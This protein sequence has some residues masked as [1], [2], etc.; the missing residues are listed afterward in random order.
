MDPSSPPLLI[1][2]AGES[3]SYGKGDLA[4]SPRVEYPTST[5]E[6][7]P[8][9]A[10]ANR[11][12]RLL[13]LALNAWI[14]FH[15]AAIVIAP[16]AVRPASD[17]VEAG[18]GLFQPY[19]QI[20]DLNH[21]YHFFAPEPEAST[22]LAFEAQR[23]DGT[24][25]KGRIPNREIVP[26]LLYHRHFMLTEQMKDAPAELQQ[27]WV[28]SY[29]EHL[30]RKYAAVRV[31]LTGQIHNLPTMEMVREGKRLD[32]PSSYEDEDLGTFECKTH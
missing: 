15:V 5:F 1:E 20:L 21:G 9:S 7:A 10:V 12:Q 18:W 32:D 29:A 14:V 11:R 19:L 13:R 27:E 30:C 6:P 4:M 28:G 24:V 17:L 3:K 16:A 23:S 8:A 2:F 31:K 26:R 25:V 22:L